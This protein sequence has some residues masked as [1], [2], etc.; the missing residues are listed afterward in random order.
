[1]IQSRAKQMYYAML[2]KQGLTVAPP[3]P[4]PTPMEYGWW[5]FNTGGVH[6]FMSDDPSDFSVAGGAEYFSRSATINGTTMDPYVQH[7]KK[8]LGIYGTEYEIVSNGPHADLSVVPATIGVPPFVNVAHAKLDIYGVLFQL[9]SSI[10]TSSY[11]DSTDAE[12]WAARTSPAGRP[13]AIGRFKS[14]RWYQLCND[15]SGWYSDDIGPPTNWKR[16]QGSPSSSIRQFIPYGDY[17]FTI[18]NNIDRAYLID[19]QINWEQRG[20][21]SYDLGTVNVQHD[22]WDRNGDTIIWTDSNSQEILRTGDF[23]LTFQTIATPGTYGGA[24]RHGGNGVW[25]MSSG[26]SGSMKYS[27]D[28]GLTWSDCILP[29]TYGSSR[30]MKAFPV[31]SNFGSA[32]A[33]EGTMR[34]GARIGRTYAGAVNIVGGCLPH[35]VTIISGSLPPGL[36]LESYGEIIGVSGTPTGTPGSHTFTVKAVDDDGREATSEQTIVVADALPGYGAHRYWRLLLTQRQTGS[37][38]AYYGLAGFDLYDVNG[39]RNITFANNTQC[40]ASSIFSASY[41]ARFAFDN[42]LSSR[43]YSANGGAEEQW[44]QYDAGVGETLEAFSVS[45]QAVDTAFASDQAPRNFSVQ[46]SD[47]GVIWSTPLNVL[48]ATGWTAAE[49]RFYSLV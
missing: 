7:G 25:V 45:I 29:T 47:D 42:S 48:G 35:A 41:P 39:I 43:W 14:G 24:I 4:G 16:C 23:G 20:D 31:I 15:N 19:D 33:I 10:N 37:P 13:M 12:T 30:R 22:N 34:E 3:P 2:G 46:Y 17:L 21:G 26:S 11:R 36:V 38:Y 40:T 1:M 44:I 28:D 27:V 9:P 18:A 8:M 5:L 6:V 32:F 49:K